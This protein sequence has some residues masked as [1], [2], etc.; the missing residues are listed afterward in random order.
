MEP[1]AE[2]SVGLVLTLEIAIG[3]VAAFSE[4]LMRRLSLDVVCQSFAQSGQTSGKRFA[5]TILHD[6]VN[7]WLINEPLLAHSI[8]AGAVLNV[9]SQ[10]FDNQSL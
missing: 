10:Q 1:G 3:A 5:L 4:R 7:V 8:A 6:P 2:E 9:G